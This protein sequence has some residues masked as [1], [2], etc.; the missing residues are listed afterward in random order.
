MESSHIPKVLDT[1]EWPEEASQKEIMQKTESGHHSN[2]WNN[3][4]VR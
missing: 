2:I 4:T 3:K 1:S